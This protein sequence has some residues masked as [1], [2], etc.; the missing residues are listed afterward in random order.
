[1]DDEIVEFGSVNAQNFQSLQNVG[2][3]VQHSQGVSGAGRGGSQHR[4]CPVPRS[5]SQQVQEAPT[6]TPLGAVARGLR[7]LRGALDLQ[8]PHA[9][10]PFVSFFAGPTIKLRSVLPLS[11]IPSPRVLP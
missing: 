6:V 8:R 9:V 7:G 10:F 11:S 4:G 5:G 3:V 2:S 1:M